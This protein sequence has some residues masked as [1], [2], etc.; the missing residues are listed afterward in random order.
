MN[1]FAEK[2][3]PIHN[4]TMTGNESVLQ[5]GTIIS[6]LPDNI[7]IN[8]NGAVKEAKKA[9]SC[10]VD[11]K[12]D[13][14]VICVRNNDGKIYILGIIERPGSQNMNFL[15]P[16][17]VNFSV[18]NGSMNIDS[19]ENI[20]IAANNLNCFSKNVIH[21]SDEAIF[22]YNT[23]RA[24]GRELQAN[25]GTVQIIS[26]IINTMA[27]QVINKFKGYIRS[28]EDNDM[29]KSGQMTRRSEGLYAVDSQHTI[30][31]SKSVTKIDGDKILMG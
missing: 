13:D 31:N 17:D 23:V 19:H 25:Y 14:V 26:N 22:S 29:V 21:K 4:Q 24:R 28:T 20:S 8:L 10:V 1:S 12:T 6:A 3:I 2:L 16:S 27:K 18:G 7:T 15:F 11:L 30:M 5:T 9:F